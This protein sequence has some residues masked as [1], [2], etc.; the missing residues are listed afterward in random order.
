[1][2]RKLDKIDAENIEATVGTSGWQ[3]IE[4]RI[5]NYL[6]NTVEGLIAT[7]NQQSTDIM[8]GEVRAIRTILA[9][10]KMLAEEGRRNGEK[11]R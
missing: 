11:A 9:F 1:M 6:R 4:E 2:A 5:Q 8:R 10:P 7:Q 3:I